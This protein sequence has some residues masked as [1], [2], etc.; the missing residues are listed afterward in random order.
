MIRQYGRPIVEN[1]DRRH[2]EWLHAILTLLIVLI[3]AGVVVYLIKSV[4]QTK[5]TQL[6][7]NRDPFDYA[8]ERFAKGEISKAELAD[9]KKEL[10]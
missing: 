7:E 3:V 6:A 9:I 8:K 4:S 5:N 10:K 1:T 2:D